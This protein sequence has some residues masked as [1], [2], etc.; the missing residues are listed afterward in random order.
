MGVGG[1]AFAFF[2]ASARIWF[3][4]DLQICFICDFVLEAG[5][6][7]LFVSPAAGR[8]RSRWEKA[9]PFFFR[10]LIK[11]VILPIVRYKLWQFTVDVLPSE[12]G[13]LLLFPRSISSR[14]ALIER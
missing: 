2:A 5:N 10:P 13:R 4:F 8:L 7:A 6:P 1:V 11:H 3:E 9:E 14:N 12:R